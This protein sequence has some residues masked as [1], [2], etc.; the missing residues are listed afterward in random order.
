MSLFHRLDEVASRANDKINSQWVRIVPKSDSVNPNAKRTAD[1]KR[2]VQDVEGIF[3]YNSIEFGM[4]LGVRKSYREANDLRNVS[5][6]RTP[7]LSIDRRWFADKDSEPR[8][9]DQIYMLK[10]TYVLGELV[11]EL[12]TSYPPYEVMDN[13]RDGLARSLLRL[14]QLGSQV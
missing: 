2:Q 8:Q 12:D 5:V 9:G 4:E 10:E 14:T 6:G 13:Q 7:D 1:P 3:E 11:L